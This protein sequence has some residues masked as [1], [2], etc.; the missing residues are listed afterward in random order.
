MSRENKGE[1]MPFEGSRAQLYRERARE[2][3]AVATNCVDGVI[4]QQLLIVAAEY[5]ALARQVEEGVLSH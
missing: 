4:R 1:T 2:V 5:D 3:R